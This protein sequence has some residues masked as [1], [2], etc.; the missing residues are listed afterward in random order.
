MV[1]EAL[2]SALPG[3]RKKPERKR[4]KLAA[5][6]PFID[7][8]LEAD[9]RAPRKQRHTARRIHQRIGAELPGCEVAESTVREYVHERKRELGWIRRETFVPQSYAW[10]SE[11]QVDWYEAYADLGGERQK[12][13]VFSM[14]SMASGGAFHRAYPRATQQAFLE[15]HELAFQYFGEVFHCLR[16]DN[17][18]SAVKKILRGYQREETGRFIAFRS[19]WGFTAEFCTPAAAHEKGG[20]EGEVGYFR[21]NH[22]VPVPQARDLDERNEQLAAACRQDQHRTIRGRGQSIGIAMQAEQEHLLPLHSEGFDLAETSFPKV[23]GS[24]C[25]RVRTNFYSVPV[26]A[27]TEVQ[28]KVYP[29]HVEVWHEGQCVARHERCYSRQQQILDREHYLDVL[30]RKPGAL[31][32]SKPLEQWRKLG[33]W[34]ASYDRFWEELIRRHGKQGGTRQMIGLLQLGKVKSYEGLQRAMEAALASG[35]WDEAAVRYL[36]TVEGEDRPPTE[37]VEVGWLGRYERPLPVMNEYD[38][39]LVAEVAR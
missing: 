25:V 9:R 4:P 11:A 6:I 26:R 38:E 21:R 17:L 2:S 18:S 16:Y 14:R 27:G 10:G 3:H 33:R 37:A 36:L 20:V 31:A 8:L 5:A 30:E 39:L 13:Q 1:R 34:P 7:I 32:G 29:G 23:D 22:W 28:A 12:L 35:C 19:H 24:G 15:A